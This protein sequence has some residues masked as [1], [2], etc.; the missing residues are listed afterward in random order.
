LEVFSIYNKVIN[1]CT[2]R[3]ITHGSLVS[4]PHSVSPLR[5]QH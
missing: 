1:V 4:N 2:K 5:T 3:V